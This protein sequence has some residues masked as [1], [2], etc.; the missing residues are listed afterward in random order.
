MANRCECRDGT[1]NAVAVVVVVRRMCLVAGA[2]N[3]N[4][5]R[6]IANANRVQYFIN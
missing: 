4:A 2:V 6:V 3:D 1:T 5:G